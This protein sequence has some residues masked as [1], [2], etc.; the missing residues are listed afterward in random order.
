MRVSELVARLRAAGSVFAEDE[1]RLL[2][3]AAEGADLERLVARRVR[4]EPLEHVLG[5]VEFAGHRVVVQPGV[6]V[7]RRRSE[8]LLREA[9]AAHP[10]IAVELCCGAAAI[11]SVLAAE[12]P[13]SAV[14]AADLDPNAVA[15]A[16]RN[17]RPDHVFAGD[18]YAALPGELRGRVDVL[19]ANAPYV[20]TAEI[21]LMPREAREHEAPMALDGGVDG[22]EVQRRIVTEAPAWLA[23]GGVLIVETS[24]R[25]ANA[26]LELA[27][28]AGLRGRIVRSEPLAATALVAG[29]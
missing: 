5:W 2:L 14:F 25:Q 28:S 21:P 1:A 19:V 24:R 7:P 20:P 18:L 27:R 29:A 17:L 9:L 22:L 23:D 6:F 10:S 12:L 3:A 16:R 15:C 26:S 13:T 4:G 8:L 11:A